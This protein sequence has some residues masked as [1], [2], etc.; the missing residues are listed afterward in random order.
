MGVLRSQSYRT[1][2]YLFV[3]GG[4][5]TREIFSF[6]VMTFFVAGKEGVRLPEGMGIRTSG[7]C[8]IFCQIRVQVMYGSNCNRFT[9]TSSE[10]LF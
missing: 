10:N 5:M 8:K 6:N 4:Q 7:A 1:V 9:S 3:K 2:L